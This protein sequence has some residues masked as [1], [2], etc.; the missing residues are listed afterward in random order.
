MMFARRGDGEASL[1]EADAAIAL[2][3]NHR[4]ARRI[5]GLVNANLA[6]T[7]SDTSHAS[8]LVDAAI[9]DLE[10]VV[11]DRLVDPTASLTLGDLYVRAGRYEQA[12]ERLRLFLLDRPRYP[13]ALLLLADAYE[14]TH[15]LPQAIEVIQQVTEAL[16][17]QGR[18][19]SRLAELQERAGQW[20]AAAG[21]WARLVERNPRNVSHRIRRATALVNTGDLAGG[22]AA[23]VEV[24][25]QDPRDIR[26]WYLLSQIDRRA[27][28]AAGAEAAARRIA[29]IDPA[30][31]RGPLALAEAR[32]ARGDYRGVVDLLDPLVRSPLDTHV[33]GGSFARMA[34]ALASAL[35]ELGEEERAVAILEQAR[36]R[37]AD[38]IDL[39]FS[40]GAAYERAE[41]FDQAEATLRQVIVRQPAHAEA[42]NYLG[43]MLADRETKL[44]EAI[45]LITRALAIEPDNPS[46]LDSLG[47]A[48]VKQAKLAEAREPLQRAAEARPKTSVIQDH[49][50]E[51]YFQLELYQEAAGVWDRALAG[52]RAGIDVSAVTRKRDRAKALA[53]RQ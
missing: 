15:Q 17:D 34:G 29:E 42:L 47:W 28:D 41:R 38:N 20:Q 33:A 13:Q 19:W 37:D 9:Q 32:A 11:A 7:V 16:P 36:R 27:G 6:S 24:T 3:P 49:L 1:R 12:I 51:L 21:T 46:F 26:A 45:D 14:R 18:V 44:D 30:D 4:S 5:R 43:Y 8:T 23:L 48:Y 31:P 10:I 35:D 52:D 40:L 50:A 39:L 2:E 25:E 22:R 53:G